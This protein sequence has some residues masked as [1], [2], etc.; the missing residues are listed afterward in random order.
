MRNTTA[1][2]IEEIMKKENRPLHLKEISQIIGKTRQA[3][4]TSIHLEEGTTF[5]KV[6]PATYFLK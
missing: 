4:Y 2:K 6:K 1:R 5:E 3:C